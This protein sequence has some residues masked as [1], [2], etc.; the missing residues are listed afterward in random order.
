MERSRMMFGGETDWFDAAVFINHNDR[1]IIY[2]C[3]IS[4]T[5][6]N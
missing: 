2:L 5:S 3:S 1:E 6:T 4:T